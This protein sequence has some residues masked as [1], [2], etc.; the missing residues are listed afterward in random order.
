MSAMIESDI[1]QSLSGITKLPVFPLL[2]PK[3]AQEGITYQR[4]SD[5]RYSSGLITTH[6]VQARF[7]V[8]IYILNDYEKALR[9]DRAVCDAWESVS[10]GYIGNH[11]VQTVQR[12]GI[13]QGREE[14]TKNTVRWSV[15]RDFIIIYP[16]GAA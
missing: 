7:Q 12:G 13:K 5:P 9:L 14:L 2:L 8:S 10:H 6:L 4:I 1:R 15:I 16:E 11:P 3:D